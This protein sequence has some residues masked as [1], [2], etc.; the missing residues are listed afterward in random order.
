MS[1]LV[2]RNDYCQF[3]LVSQTNYTLLDPDSST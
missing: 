2:T 3:L 1:G